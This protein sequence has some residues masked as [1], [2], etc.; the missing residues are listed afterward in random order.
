MKIDSLAFFHCSLPFLIVFY[1]ALSGTVF[2]MI[3]HSKQSSFFMSYL[4]LYGE[5]FSFLLS[6]VFHN[7]DLLCN[8][9]DFGRDMSYCVSP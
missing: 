4:L 5:F 6:T 8:R 2:N 9:G 1:I 3:A 7:P